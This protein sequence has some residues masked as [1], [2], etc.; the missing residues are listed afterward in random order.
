MN[1]LMTKFHQQLN[2]INAAYQAELAATEGRQPD[3][4]TDN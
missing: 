3:S 2:E 1:Q 4:A